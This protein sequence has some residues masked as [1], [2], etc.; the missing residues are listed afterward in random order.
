MEQVEFV[1]I[2]TYQEPQA[3]CIKKG[4]VSTFADAEIEYHAHKSDPNCL[5]VRI[6]CVK[7]TTMME[8]ER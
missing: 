3:I 2:S 6:D 7:T 5:A 4:T 1:I 8:F